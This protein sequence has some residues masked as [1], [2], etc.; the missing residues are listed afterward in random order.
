MADKKED[1]K[2]KLD[3]DKLKRSIPPKKEKPVKEPVVVTQ[4]A[5]GMV[6]DFMFNPT[7]DSIRSATVID[8]MQ[9]RFFPQLDMIN[10]MFGYYLEMACYRENPDYYAE[11]FEKEYPEHPNPMEELMY[12]TAQWQRSVGGKTM[13]EGLEIVK[14]EKEA[15]AQEDDYGRGNDPWKDSE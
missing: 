7:R 5:I 15:Q 10:L 13:N 2:A 4:G 8:R 12:R 6:T 14:V 3:T 1:I 9:G 11:A